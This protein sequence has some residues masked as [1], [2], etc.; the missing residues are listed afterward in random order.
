MTKKGSFYR[1]MQFSSPIDSIKSPEINMLEP[2]IKNA[3]KAITRNFYI[4][5]NFI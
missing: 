1:R 5:L 3:Y 4:R 2:G